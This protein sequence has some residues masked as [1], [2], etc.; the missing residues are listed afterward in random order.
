MS[1][2]ETINYEIATRKLKSFIDWVNADTDL[3][4]LEELEGNLEDSFDYD[5]I[6]VIEHDDVDEFD[7]Q[8]VM[9][10][11]VGELDEEFDYTE[12]FA[13]KANDA[14]AMSISSSL[15]SL[16]P[17]IRKLKR[18]PKTQ[19]AYQLFSLLLTVS[20]IAVLIITETN[21]PAFGDPENPTVN[22]VY[23]RYIEQGV[24]DTGALN[25]V[26]A[27]ILDY[28]AF[29]TLGEAFVLLTAVIAVVMLIR[30]PGA[31][32]PKSKVDMA[33]QPFMLKYAV[34]LVVPFI[35]IFGI[36]IL[37]N[38]HLSPGGGFSGGA[39]LGAGISLYAASYGIEK[40]RTIFTFKTFIICC[41]SAL[42]F[43]S[44]AKGYSFMMG[45]SGLSAGIPLGTPGNL[46]SAGLIMPLNVSVGFVVACSAYGFYALFSE[47]EV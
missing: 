21:M 24:E 19:L 38:G 43:Y 6:E 46:F 34:M 42:L 16:K 23:I 33:E 20:I 7:I 35:I 44:L 2:K 36:Y 5:N 25:I 10:T 31:S 37:L 45:A 8:D 28:R 26:A 9:E 1:E 27:M 29:D 40:V 30:T 14:P 32:A 22:E 39:V 4:T 18:L 41:V 11:K 3:P 15:V 17:W 13:S 47:G 12:M